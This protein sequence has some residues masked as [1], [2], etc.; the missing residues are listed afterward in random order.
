MI[1][2]PRNRRLSSLV[3]C[4]APLVL[5]TTAAANMPTAWHSPSV[6]ENLLSPASNM[7]MPTY[8]IGAGTNVTL[9]TGVYIKEKNA[10]I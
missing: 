1:F 3:R 7:R 6:T 8:E 9:Y 4:F 5:L 10:N 2:C